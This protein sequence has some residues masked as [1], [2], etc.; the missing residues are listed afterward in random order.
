MEDVVA[1]MA[2][3]LPRACHEFARRQIASGHGDALYHASELI[4]ASA[5]SAQLD[6]PA[7]LVA[8]KYPEHFEPV[9]PQLLK[10]ILNAASNGDEKTVRQRLAN[11]QFATITALSS[12]ATHLK[13]SCEQ[14]QRYGASQIDPQGVLFRK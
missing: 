11:A 6:R 4:H 2:A 7:D 5:F 3:V 9:D 13:Q 14:I 1:G 8:W 10:Q 12:I